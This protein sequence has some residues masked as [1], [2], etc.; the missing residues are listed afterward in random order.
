M[1]LIHAAAEA[2]AASA[3]AASIRLSPL[4]PDLSDPV[5]T[6]PALSLCQPFASAA[7]VDGTKTLEGRP[8]P[9]LAPLAGQWVAV[10]AGR[11]A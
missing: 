1:A 9:V 2:S 4:D 5:V 6:Y 11:G 7:A 3:P 8:A 10:R